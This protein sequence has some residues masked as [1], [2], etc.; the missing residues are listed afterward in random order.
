MSEELL[1]RD[2]IKNPEKIGKWDFYN[3]GATSVRALREYGIVRDVDYG[4][5]EKKKVDGLLVLKKKVVAVIEY[6]KP[7]EFKTTAQKR[8]AIEQELSVARKLKASIL[9]A[10][11]TLETIWINVLTG[12]KILDETGQAIKVKFDPTHDKLP[13]LI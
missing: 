4:D 5:D 2:L 3:I 7:S 12:N 13:E 9:I 11:D 8:K 10:T 6:K 1:Q